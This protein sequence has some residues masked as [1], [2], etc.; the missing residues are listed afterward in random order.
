MNKY[1]I[2]FKTWKEGTVTMPG[3]HKVLGESNEY[4]S[5][6]NLNKQIPDSSVKSV[7]LTFNESAIGDFLKDNVSACIVAIIIE[8]ES[9]DNALK[10]LD[11]YLGPIEIDGVTEINQDNI[12]I[13]EKIMGKDLIEPSP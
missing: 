12:T 3:T 5:R 13:I 11:D 2:E 8:E 10:L 1:Y 9:V 7:F 6:K 4:R